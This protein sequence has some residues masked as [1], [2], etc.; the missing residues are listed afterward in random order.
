MANKTTRISLNESRKLFSK[1]FP[2]YLRFAVSN[3][4]NAI[5]YEGM[6]NHE[7]WVESNLVNRNNFLLG[8]GHGK[9]AFRFQKSKPSHDISTIF[10]KSGSIDRAGSKKYDFMRDQNEG[11]RMTG[12]TP[13]LNARTGKNYSK[14][15]PK[16]K[17]RTKSNIENLRG[18]VSS[19]RMSILYIRRLFTKQFALPGSNQFFYMKDNQFAN[20]GGGLYQFAKRIKSDGSQFPRIKKLYTG[21]KQNK[22]FRKA[23]NWMEKSNKL[24]SQDYIDNV[25]DRAAN[26]AFSGQLKLWRN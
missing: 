6:K 7:Y 19:K 14:I 23:T 3:T 1:T 16:P 22:K 17:R 10:S 2:N 9:G 21:G 26:Q 8:N 15:I 25:F 4:M 13:T 11:F 12:T 18:S 20:F 24:L 5:A